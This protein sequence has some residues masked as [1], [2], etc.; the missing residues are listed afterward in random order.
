MLDLGKFIILRLDTVKVRLDVS[1]VLG[2]R[3]HAHQSFDSDVLAVV[4]NLSDEISRIIDADAELA[5]FLCRIDLN[6]NV[7]RQIVSLGALVDLLCE[8]H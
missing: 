8:F 5:L 1:R 7:H 2:D 6:Q 4:Q 3:C